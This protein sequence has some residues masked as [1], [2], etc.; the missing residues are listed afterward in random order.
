[1]IMI[2]ENRKGMHKCM[3]DKA[4]AFVSIIDEPHNNMIAHTTIFY[5]GFRIHNI[6]ICK[7][8]TGELYVE[9]PFTFRRKNGEFVKDENG[10]TIKD[11][12]VR[13]LNVEI[14]SEI[15]ELVFTEYYR[16]LEENMELKKAE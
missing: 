14:R 8:K 12:I 6:N 10:Y 13:P 1:M 9:F 5:R 7:K 15:E 3:E 11:Y 2:T 16:I 4:R